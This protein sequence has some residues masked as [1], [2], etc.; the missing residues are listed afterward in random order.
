MRFAR[1]E[2]LVIHKLVAGQPRDLED[3][4]SILARK[5]NLDEAYLKRWLPM[6]RGA[7]GHDLL[8]DLETIRKDL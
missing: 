1:V 3:I 8:R 4:R 5:P 6:F 7:V 2:D